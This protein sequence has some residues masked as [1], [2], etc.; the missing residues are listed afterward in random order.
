M[1]ACLVVSKRWCPF[2]RAYLCGCCPRLVKEW[3][4]CW[5]YWGDACAVK[6]RAHALLSC[7]RVSRPQPHRARK[8]S[9]SSITAA[10]KGNLSTSASWKPL[11]RAETSCSRAICK[12]GR[13]KTAQTRYVKV[14]AV[15]SDPATMR[16]DASTW[17]SFSSNVSPL[18]DSAKMF[19]KMFLLME[20]LTDQNPLIVFLISNILF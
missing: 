7:H 11:G 4:D 13:D 14:T 1:Q 20:M 2:E 18:S 15:V 9:V 3:E 8:R 10:S 17:T 19:A 5:N 16:A 12:S 6:A